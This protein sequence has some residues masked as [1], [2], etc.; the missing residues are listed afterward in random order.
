VAGYRRD[1]RRG[2]RALTYLWHVDAGVPATIDSQVAVRLSPTTFSGGNYHFDPRLTAVLRKY[3]QPGR[4]F[5]DIGAHMGIASVMYAALTDTGTRVI[6]IEPNPNVFPLLIANSQVNGMRIDC[7]R[8][9]F[10]AEVGDVSLFVD[11]RDPNAS[12][13]REA[14]GKYGCWSAHEK[15]SLQEFR[16]ARTTVDKFCDAF[17]LTPGLIKLDVEG[18]EFEVLRGAAR[19]LRECRPLILMEAHVFAWDGFGYTGKDLERVI[20]EAGYTIC[21]ALGSKFYGPLGTGPE[22]DNNQYLLKPA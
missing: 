6:A 12:L 18:A 10:G 17:G 2:G 3:A 15:P 14:P 7:F 11:G 5:L 20:R 1:L 16:V 21:D 19:T 13:S 9:A 8:L 22:R 4:A